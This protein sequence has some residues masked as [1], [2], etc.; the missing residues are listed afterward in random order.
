[1]VFVESFEEKMAKRKLKDKEIISELNRIRIRLYKKLQIYS[2][3]VEEAES[4]KKEISVVEK[5][6][7]ELKNKRMTKV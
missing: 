2:D 7:K 1:M 6:I 3:N 5:H 4:I